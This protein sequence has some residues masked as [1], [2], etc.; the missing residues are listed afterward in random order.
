MLEAIEILS[1]CYYS[2]KTKF[3]IVLLRTHGVHCLF[4]VEMEISCLRQLEILSLFKQCLVR[5]VCTICVLAGCKF[6]GCG[7]WNCELVQFFLKI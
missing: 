1:L 7:R 5:K 3:E 4:F 2:L 6:L